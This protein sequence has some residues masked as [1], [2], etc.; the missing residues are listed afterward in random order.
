MKNTRAIN[1]LWYEVTADDT[2][3]IHNTISRLDAYKQAD[4]LKKFEL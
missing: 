2:N 4:R 3:I 1:N